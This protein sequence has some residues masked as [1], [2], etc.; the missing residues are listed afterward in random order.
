MLT[1]EAVAIILFFAIYTAL[2]KRFG[3]KTVVFVRV[4]VFLKPNAVDGRLAG[5]ALLQVNFFRAATT[6]EDTIHRLGGEVIVRPGPGRPLQAKLP[7]GSLPKL[8]QSDLV[9]RVETA[10]AVAFEIGSRR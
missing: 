2:G 7:R 6:L 9:E 1:I 8:A 4:E 3:R 10:R 5:T